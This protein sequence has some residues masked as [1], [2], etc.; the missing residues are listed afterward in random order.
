MNIANSL[1]TVAVFA[2]AF[3]FGTVFTIP[4][5][6]SIPCNDSC[7]SVRT[8]LAF[9]F[10]CFVGSLFFTISVQLLL[11]NEKPDNTIDDRIKGRLV[12][13]SFRCSFLGLI[14]G[15]IL[16]SVILILSGQKVAGGLAITLVAFLLIIA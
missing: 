14:I 16:L 15:F 7:E 1:A 4:E 6:G 13:N 9:A 3:T 2:G 8:L 5:N 11:Q 12:H 10:V